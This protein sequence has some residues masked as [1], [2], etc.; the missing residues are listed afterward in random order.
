MAA[1]K[2]PRRSYDPSRRARVSDHLAQVGRESHPLA[3]RYLVD[4]SIG[5]HAAF[6]IVLRG[7]DESAW[8]VLSQAAN[9]SLILAEDGF[10]PEFIPDIKR[11]QDALMRA[12]FR[13][14]V[15]ARWGFDGDGIADL[16]TL[17]ELHDR[18][19]EI[20]TR[21]DVRKVIREMNRRLAAGDILEIVK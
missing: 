6:A 16:R 7:G 14:R 9:V 20:A 10:G 11:A 13:A 18:Q 2:K 19:M 5:I 4:L 3:D 8:S 17:V 21:A 1:N 12:A 15:A